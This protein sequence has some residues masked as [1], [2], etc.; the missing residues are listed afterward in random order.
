METRANYV[1]VGAFTLAGFI[2]LL[3]FF[4]WF[5][6][7]ELDRQYDYYDIDFSTVSGLTNASDVRFAGLPVGQVVDVSLSPDDNGLVRVRIEVAAETPIR[8]TSIATI[9]SLGVTGVSFVSL[10]AGD[11]RDPLL[12]MPATGDI[13]MINSGRSVLQA[14]SEDAPTIVE[15]V[16]SVSRQ[17][18]QLLGPENQARVSTVLANLERSTGDLEQALADFSSVADTIATSSDELV[19]FTAKLDEISAATASVLETA[20][21]TLVSI[22]EIARRA[23]GTLDK[24]D[25]MLESGQ[26]ALASADLFI[27]RDLNR[28]VENLAATSENVRRQID[29]LAADTS[30]TMEEFRKAGALAGDFILKADKTLETTDITLADMSVAAVAV[31]EAATEFDLLVSESGAALVSEARSFIAD[32]G[33]VVEA[34][35]KVAETDLPAIIEDIRGATETAARVIEEV[36]TDLSA[37]AGRADAIS[38]NVATTL[39]SVSR[40]FTN[41]N[42]TLNRLNTALETGDSA[43]AAADRVLTS[44]DL[45]VNEDLGPLTNELRAALSRLDTAI[46]LVTE[47]LPV[48]TSELR[49]TA[50]TANAA[51]N[52]VG[53]TATSLGPPL[54][55]FANEGLPQYSRL[56]LETRELVGNLDR[57][58]RRIERDPAR[59][60]LGRD[61]PAFRR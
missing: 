56:A 47:D 37:A 55:S 11:P 38:A 8:G 9:E 54:R 60:F 41:A 53:Q 28:V 15:E 31:E 59:Y 19:A 50:E 14:I 24:G 32:A 22:T 12:A 35:A 16:L 39:D 51:F 44:A 2:G 52:E 33:R 30:A 57:L 49:K 13:P 27:T 25:A 58:V 45:L 40:T 36:G 61:E 34:A 7:V 18:G 4:V 42:D 29:S 21:T 17:L 10:S 6:Q 46:V 23:E 43:L 20:D 3:L 1:L 26:T 48:I 5:A